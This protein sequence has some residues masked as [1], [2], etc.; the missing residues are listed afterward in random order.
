VAGPEALEGTVAPAA[1]QVSAASGATRAPE[2][3]AEAVAS[4]RWTTAE[5]VSD[6][7]PKPAMTGIAEATTAALAIA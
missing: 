1:L 7:R 5:T 2:A 4:I 3:T 6:S